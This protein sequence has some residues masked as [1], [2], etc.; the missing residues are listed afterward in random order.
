MVRQLRRDWLAATGHRLALVE[1]FVDTERF[2]GTCYNA[3][4]WLDLGR[5]TGRTRDDRHRTISV[6]IKQVRVL[7]LIPVARV[8]RELAQ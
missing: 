2:Q 3:A 1:T 7:P 8:R 5:T 6:P 4:N